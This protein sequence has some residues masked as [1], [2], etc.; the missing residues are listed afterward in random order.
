MHIYLAGRNRK[1]PLV[2]LPKL[3]TDTRCSD[4]RASAQLNTV[5]PDFQLSKV[6]AFS[7]RIQSQVL[8]VNLNSGLRSHGSLRSRLLQAVLCQLN[9]SCKQS[10]THLWARRH[11]AWFTSFGS[12]TGSP[13]KLEQYVDRVSSSL[14]RLDFL[15]TS[16][17][18]LGESGSV[19]ICDKPFTSSIE[20][21]CQSGLA[22]RNQPFAL[23]GGSQLLS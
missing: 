14:F 12:K 13:D 20:G 11:P 3:K 2:L 10:C 22:L 8:Y 19:R 6:P 9:R 21:L 18:P 16:N 17:L 23:T 4:A 1:C 7:A 15:S 5:C